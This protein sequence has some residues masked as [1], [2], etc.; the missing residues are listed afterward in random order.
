[1]KKIL[2][3]LGALGLIATSGITTISCA[4]DVTRHQFSKISGAIYD[5][6]NNLVLLPEE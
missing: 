1:M 4:G 5:D 2:S 6:K 3:L